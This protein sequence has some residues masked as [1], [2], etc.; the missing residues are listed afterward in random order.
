M[1]HKQINITGEIQNLGLTFQVMM[2]AEELNLKGYAKYLTPDKIRIEA[3]GKEAD[4]NTLISWCETRIPKTPTLEVKFTNS[5]IKNYSNFTIGT[6][7]NRIT[8]N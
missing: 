5:E 3:E 7:K 2:K 1:L 8:T 4:I 6:I